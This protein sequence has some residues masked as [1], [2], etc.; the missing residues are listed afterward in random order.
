M[1]EVPVSVL[2]VEDTVALAS[3]YSAVLENEGISVELAHL[4]A[5]ALRKLSDGSYALVLLDLQLP[6]ADGLELLREIRAAGDQTTV[7]VVTSDASVDRAMEAIRSGARDYLVKPLAPERL[8]TTVRNALELVSLRER[9]MEEA[10]RTE[11]QGFIGASKAMQAIY[12]SLAN[13]APSSASVFITGESGTGKELCAEA[14]HRLS[15]RSEGPF[16]AINCGAI[17]KDLIETE[18]FGHVKGAF[19][20]AIA[21]RD[22]AAS[23]A[24]GGTLFL[25]EICEMDVSLQTKLLRFLQTS[26]FQRVGSQTTERV[27]VR[28]V[29]ATNRDPVA[30]LAAGRFR[31]DL[32]YRLN[33]IPIHLPPLR[34]R[35]DD[36]LLIANRFFE[37]FAEEEGKE[38]SEISPEAADAIRAYRWPGNVRELEN[39]VRR[40][41]VMNPGGI[42]EI[43]M[44][45]REICAP[46]SQAGEG[47]AAGAGGDGRAE[48]DQAGDAL[49][50]AKEEDGWVP[51][52]R[53]LAEIERAVIE[54][55]I[56]RCDGSVTKAAHVLDVSPSTLY[57]KR[58]AW[59]DS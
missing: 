28:V 47:S 24:D 49:S 43:D 42:V 13:I 57:R 58:S 38:L 15:D 16:I 2:L 17:P 37:R 7:I 56:R 20:G 11:F 29:C 23:Q 19:T 27:D 30:E 48:P 32:Y 9:V 8:L 5:D 53:S 51:P 54:A 55:T 34:E 39:V 4:G 33:V 22:G 6:D 25:D 14:I 1:G 12:R 36:V 21:N 10:E 52:D 45:P 26:S 46:V 35:E 40:V 3:A 18:L 59:A 50:L 41:V 44:L 31:E